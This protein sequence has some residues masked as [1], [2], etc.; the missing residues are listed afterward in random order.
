MDNQQQA[1]TADDL[2]VVATVSKP[3]GVNGAMKVRVESHNPGRFKPGA[4]LLAVVAGTA[5]SF[6]VAKFVPQND[7]GILTLA[8]VSSVEQAE[9]LRGAD[10]G[11]RERE[12]GPLPAGCYYTFQIIGLKVVSRT[13]QEL[14]TVAVVEELPAGDAYVVRGRG[15]EFRVPA[16][17]GFIQ[18]ID[19]DRGLMVIDDVEGLR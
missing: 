11:V 4:K 10:L 9:Q 2:I 13:G 5:R 3:H 16:Q 12:L 15:A 7:W 1:K 18:S 6:T 17:G 19:L 8:E 14:G